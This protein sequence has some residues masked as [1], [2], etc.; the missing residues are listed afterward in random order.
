V[1]GQ[2]S[3]I[4]LARFLVLHGA[5]TNSKNALGDTP[6]SLAKRCGNMELVLLLSANE[7]QARASASFT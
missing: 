4:E 6:E 2:D 3:D 7:Q 5:Q 1:C